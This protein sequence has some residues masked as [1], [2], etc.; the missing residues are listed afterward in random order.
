MTG[1]I[2]I[3]ATETFTTEKAGLFF[4]ISD[5]SRCFCVIFRLIGERLWGRGQWFGFRFGRWEG[6]FLFW[7]GV[8][9]FGFKFKG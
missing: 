4:S 2:L 7:T 5:T 3:S 8:V 6:G 1:T 9:E